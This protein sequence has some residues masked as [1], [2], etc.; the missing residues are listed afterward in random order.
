MVGGFSLLEQLPRPVVFRRT[1]ELL[2]VDD[3]AREESGRIPGDYGKYRLDLIRKNK[4]G[5]SPKDA[6][7]VTLGVRLLSSHFP[8]GY[9]AIS[10]G[11]GTWLF[12]MLRT[13][14]QD[15]AT[16]GPRRRRRLQGGTDEPFVR[17]LR[18][19]RQ[20]YEGKS[21]STRELLDV[22][23]EEFHL[24]CAMKANVLWI[25]SWRDG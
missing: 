12:H 24:R 13:M 16:P 15:G 22:F 23:A 7:P 17:A 6:G 25:G 21:I 14:L 3:G 8:E 1:G 20:R 9:E 4:D 11:R 5:V 10:Y 2:L 18:K 19:V